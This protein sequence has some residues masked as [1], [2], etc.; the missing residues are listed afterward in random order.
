MI[1]LFALGACGA[2]VL[3]AG[4]LATPPYLPPVAHLLHLAPLTADVWSIIFAFSLAPL[5]VAQATRVVVGRR[6][7]R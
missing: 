6:H 2:L 3:C 1:S 7:T 4:L 5:I